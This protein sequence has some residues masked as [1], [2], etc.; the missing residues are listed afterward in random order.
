MI[1]EESF[2]RKFGE[3]TLY[4]IYKGKG[5]KEDLKSMTFIHSKGYLPRTV[6][7]VVV[8]GMKEEILSG[9]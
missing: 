9:S 3:T 1:E 2:G 7:A 6:E 5:N 8:D 4:N